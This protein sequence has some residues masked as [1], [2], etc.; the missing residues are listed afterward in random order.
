MIKLWNTSTGN[1]VKE[2]KGHGYEVLGL[3]VYVLLSPA[4]LLH[5]ITGS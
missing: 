1:E 2:Y 3:C 4:L 5:F